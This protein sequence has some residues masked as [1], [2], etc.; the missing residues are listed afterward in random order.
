MPYKGFHQLQSK[1]EITDN[2]AKIWFLQRYSKNISETYF[3]TNT[4]QK[5]DLD[6]VRVIS[7]DFVF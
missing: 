3:L 6:Y 2:L 7:R 5:P 4:M 1:F